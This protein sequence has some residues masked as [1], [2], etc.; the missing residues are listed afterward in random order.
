MYP[1]GVRRRP[2]LEYGLCYLFSIPL[3]FNGP[4]FPL[5]KN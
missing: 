1:M 5:L 3:I 2:G 4:H